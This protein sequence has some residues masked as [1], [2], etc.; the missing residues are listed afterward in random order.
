M[1]C[2]RGLSCATIAVCNRASLSSAASGKLYELRHYKIKPDRYADFLK[3]VK[4][5]YAEVMMPHGK[6]V[7]YWAGN[8]GGLNEVQHLWEY[9]E[10][11]EREIHGE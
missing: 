1:R 9:G 7:G 6:M 3:L 8:V 2:R 4:E 11:G 10:R 5:K